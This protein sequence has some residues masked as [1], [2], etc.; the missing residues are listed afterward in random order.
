MNLD[1]FKNKL[2]II[3]RYDDLDT[4][5]HVNNKVFLSYLEEARIFYM[6]EVMGFTPK[7]M[8]FEAVV[9]RINISYKAPLLLFDEVTVFSRCSRIGKKSYDLEHLIVKKVENREIISAVSTVTMVSFDLKNGV[10]KANSNEMIEKVL[11]YEIQKP[12]LK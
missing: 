3:I 12:L 10:S 9:G 5:N 8:D 2:S 6:K 11:E 7:N 4:Y 1:L